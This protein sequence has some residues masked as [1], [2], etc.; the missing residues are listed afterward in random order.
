MNQEL[1]IVS[2]QII[3]RK[4]CTDDKTGKGGAI[5]RVLAIIMSNSDTG[6]LT[7]ANAFIFDVYKVTLRIIII[8]CTTCD[9]CLAWSM[10]ITTTHPLLPY[11]RHVNY[12]DTPLRRAAVWKSWTSWSLGPTGYSG[13]ARAVLLTLF[14]RLSRLYNYN[15]QN[16]EGIWYPFLLNFSTLVIVISFARMDS[17]S[18]WC[19]R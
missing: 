16:I 4:I 19:C 5:D 15:I 7:I 14:F 9:D 11:L 6:C 12:T 3:A 1:E 18:G 8:K 17:V 13:W 10:T 2:R